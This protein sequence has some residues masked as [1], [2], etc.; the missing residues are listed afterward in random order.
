VHGSVLDL[1]VQPLGFGASLV[2]HPGPSGNDVVPEGCEIPSSDS[3]VG[4]ALLAQLQA[5][6][7]VRRDAMAELTDL[8][9]PL[10][11]RAETLLATLDRLLVRLDSRLMGAGDAP[12]G[13][14]LATVDTTTREFGVLAATV[15]QRTEE[16]AAI[17]ANLQEFSE[18]LA[19]PEGLVPTLLG[20]EGTAAALFRDQAVLYQQLVAVMDEMTQLSAYLN[21]SAPEISALLDESTRTLAESE[22]VLQGL[23]NNPLLRGGIPDEPTLPGTFEGRRDLGVG[24]HD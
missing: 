7:T 24:H 11:V 20:D 4:R 23:K 21:R 10:L 19:Q 17:M 16:L 18:L 8:V 5:A 2:L 12:D 3:D 6:G 1:A 13:G 9:P 15:N 14:L 22:K